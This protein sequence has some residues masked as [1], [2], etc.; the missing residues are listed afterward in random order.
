MRLVITGTRGANLFLW[1]LS[2]LDDIPVGSTQTP[3]IPRLSIAPDNTSL[4]LL[5]W[6]S[7][8]EWIAFSD[9]L[10]GVYVMGVP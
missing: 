10:G 1:D 2:V 5:A 7:D 9:L 8:N 6:S 3:Q 4:Y